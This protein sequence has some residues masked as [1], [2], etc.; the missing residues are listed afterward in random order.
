M[1]PLPSP[2]AFRL[3]A[4]Q[5]FLLL[6]TL[7]AF[8]SA[9]PAFADVPPRVIPYRRPA[10]LTQP[11]QPTAQSHLEAAQRA[12]DLASDLLLQSE[13]Q[14]S[15]LGTITGHDNLVM[16]YGGHFQRVLADLPAAL[17]AAKQA[18]A[19]VREHPETNVLTAGPAPAGDSV[20]P[21]R[22]KLRATPAVTNAPALE[23]AVDALDVAFDALANNPAPDHRG[24]VLGDL[25]GHRAKLIA[26]IARVAADLDLAASYRSHVRG[27]ETGIIPV[28]A[29]ANVRPDPEFGPT[30]K[31][32]L[33]QVQL[34]LNG[35]KPYFVGPRGGQPAADPTQGGF[36]PK[37]TASLAR[38][39]EHM[40][41]ALA[42]LRDHPEAAAL[43]SGPAK[44]DPS[45]AR[46]LRAP[47][48]A[49]RLP[50]YK[51]AQPPPITANTLGNLN[52]ALELLTNNSAPSYQG[53]VLGDLGGHR[54]KIMDAIG[55]ALTDTLAALKL[56]YPE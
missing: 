2:S 44:P 46:Q 55:D 20:P 21:T 41:A 51:Q 54:G 36:V 30:A 45:S 29:P 25:G 49:T 35:A 28:S 1:T 38:I 15:Q 10:Q 32:Y 53:P 11:I 5:S 22:P 23:R 7:L 4:L 16:L 26:A 6:T 42:Y 24:P 33:A 12:L 43:E 40:E 31:S 56:A 9:R 27:G 3:S 13:G 19:Y 47:A 39:N 18:L 17:D 8:S 14:P 52:S 50:V 48:S 34:R 37:L